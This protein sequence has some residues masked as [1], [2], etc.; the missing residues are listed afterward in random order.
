MI[1]LRWLVRPGW[2]GPE[3]VLQYR[4]QEHNPPHWIDVPVVDENCNGLRI[5]CGDLNDE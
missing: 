5:P 3:R 2:D 1:E 4:N